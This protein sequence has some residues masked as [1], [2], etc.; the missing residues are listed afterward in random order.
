MNGNI[1]KPLGFGEILDQTFR[2]IKQNIKPIFL[3]T[4][5]I[6]VPIFLIQ[7]VVLILTGRELFISLDSSQSV[8]S[9][10]IGN[11]DS[12]ANTSN[13]ENLISNAVSMI[14]FFAF[15]LLAGAIILAVKQAR[16]GGQIIVKDMI[17]G[18]LPRYF[19]ML[20]S[21]LLLSIIAFAILFPS[22]IITVI[23]GGSSGAIFHPVAGVIIIFLLLAGLFLALG[24]LL[25]RWSLFLPAVLFEKVAPGLSR[26]WHLTKRQTWKFFGL[27]L[28]LIII[29]AIITSLLQM[30]LVFLG[31]SVLYYVLT[32]VFSLISSIIIYVGYSVLYFDASIRQEGSDLQSLINEYQG[33]Q[34]S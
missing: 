23:I 21:T 1:H 5:F 2:I 25:T 16:N 32:N 6:M 10:L 30:P 27:L 20:F 33:T 3:I 11:L 17:K 24:L 29:S 31:N 18:A 15:P 8:F 28:V 34:E 19:P 4:F 13:E 14:S 12:I 26:S 7:A 9:S 22:F